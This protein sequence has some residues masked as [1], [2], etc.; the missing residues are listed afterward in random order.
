MTA[1]L[2]ADAACPCG[3]R[4]YAHCCGPFI[5][6]FDTCP[7][8]DAQ[9][10]MRSRY[11]AFT[12]GRWQHVRA[13]WWPERCPAELADMPGTKWLGLEVRSHRV[14]DDTHQEVE[15]VARYRVQG[16]AV[17]LHERSR[18]VHHEGRWWYVDGDD[19]SVKG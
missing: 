19:L 7:A 11:T 2:P 18:F 6:Q 14:V 10:L 1:S 15:F 12:L 17:R 9:A 4:A 3:R 5:E 8:P 16:R 13:T